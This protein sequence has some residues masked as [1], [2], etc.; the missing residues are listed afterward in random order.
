MNYWESRHPFHFKTIYEYQQ[1]SEAVKALIQKDPGQYVLQQL[2]SEELICRRHG[3]D[4]QIVLSDEML[5][6]L[7]RW[8]HAAATHAEGMDRLEVSI[9]RYFH[10]P[11]I[12]E[13][14]WKVVGFLLMR[15]L[16]LYIDLQVVLHSKFKHFPFQYTVIIILLL[17]FIGSLAIWRYVCSEG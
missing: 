16:V 11:K 17:L 2:G 7:V 8:Y 4:F 14:V 3:D 13:E 5:P 9:K 1:R 10:H 12:R 6:K 15:L